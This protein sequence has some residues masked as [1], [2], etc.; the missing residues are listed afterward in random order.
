MTEHDLI[1]YEELTADN[2][3]KYDRRYDIR[4]RAVDLEFCRDLRRS[5]FEEGNKRGR[6]NHDERI[7]LRHPRNEDRRETDRTDRVRRA[8]R[9]VNAADDQKSDKTADRAGK[10]HRSDDDFLDV[11]S[12]IKRGVSAFS[13]NGDLISV[14]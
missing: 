10:K 1:I 13:D 14:L 8:D 12:Y 6:E 7:E 2:E 5:D 3:E 4:D 11:D 9:A